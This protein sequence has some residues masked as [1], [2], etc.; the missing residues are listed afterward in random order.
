VEYFFAH[1]ITPAFVAVLVPA[2]VL[3][4]LVAF[5]WPMALVVAP[6]L[7]WA[8]LGPILGRARIDRLASRAREATGE[9]NAYAVDSVQGLAE[10]AQ[11]GRQLA[12]TLGAARRLHAID[13]EPVPVTNGAG[14]RASV[15][16]AP[17]LEMSHV[18]FSYPGRPRPALDD[19]SFT[20]PLG[21]T[22]ALVGPSG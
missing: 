18:R 19:V 14:V 16:G 6:F 12:D 3:G 15:P 10:I 9:L 13:T 8:A 17:A 22:V 5:G 21:S 20:V 4:T 7:V 2:A 1:T 11:V